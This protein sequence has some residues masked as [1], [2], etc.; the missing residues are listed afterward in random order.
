MEIFSFFGSL[1]QTVLVIPITNILV[2]LYST[3]LYLHVPYAL[4]FAIVTLTVLIRLVLY[5]LTAA[6]IR[7]AKVMQTIGPEVSELRKKYKSDKARQQQ[8][9]MKLYKKHNV[10][11]ASG[12]LPLLVQ[13]PVIWSL[14]NVLNTIFQ[15]S[16]QEGVTRINEI[17]YFALF[18]LRESWNTIFLG[19]D[20]SSVPRDVFSDQPLYLI[21][22]VLTGIL[23]F[24]LSK[25]MII[26]QSSAKKSSDDFQAIFQKQSVFIFPF[27]IGYFSF[28]FPVGLS[29]YWNTFTLFGILQQYLLVGFGGL[30]PWVHKIQN[31]S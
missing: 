19:L 21:V 12:C 7:S 22:P 23:Q 2:I 31:R 20:L 5:P 24:V 8:E 11:P 18:S 29:V 3:L 13:I 15:E 30:E 9:M 10:N 14:Y 17:V 6:Q 1:F 16:A 25:M 26:P 4:G 28:I 27:M